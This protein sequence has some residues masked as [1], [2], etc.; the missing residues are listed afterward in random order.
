MD[1]YGFDSRQTE[2]PVTVDTHDALET[3]PEALP[4]IS[5]HLDLPAC[6]HAGNTDAHM[7][8]LAYE[9]EI[10][11][12]TRECKPDGTA[13]VASAATIPTI[14]PDGRVKVRPLFYG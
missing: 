14:H 4:H 12:D 7:A 1:L 9:A 11:P 10:N 2:K 13:I 5:A 8:D 3:R 6:H